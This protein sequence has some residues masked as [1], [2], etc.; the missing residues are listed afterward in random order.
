MALEQLADEHNTIISTDTNLAY[1]CFNALAKVKQSF[2][3][4]P[5]VYHEHV[6]IL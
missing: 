1:D 6:I 2:A 4:I 3:L 5:T